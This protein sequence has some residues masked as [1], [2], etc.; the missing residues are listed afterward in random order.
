MNI[1]SVNNFNLDTSSAIQN[2]N[3][4]K[5]Q[6]RADEVKAL[7]KSRLNRQIVQDPSLV[8][9]IVALESTMVYNSSAELVQAVS[10]S[11]LA[12]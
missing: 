5:G 11:R 2:E 6:S 8:S 1:S 3:A 7:Q 12:D 9:K 10:A 4:A